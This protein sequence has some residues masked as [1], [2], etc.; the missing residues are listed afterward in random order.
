M[1][2]DQP[3]T[4]PDLID[5]VKLSELPP[6]VDLT[7][8]GIIRYQLESGDMMR[9]I[10]ARQFRDTLPEIIEPVEVV[11]RTGDGTMRRLGTWYPAVEAGPEANAGFVSRSSSALAALGATPTSGEPARQ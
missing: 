10:S 11:L 8:C 4:A 7:P 9:T 3:M 6:D 2:E 5:L 1:S